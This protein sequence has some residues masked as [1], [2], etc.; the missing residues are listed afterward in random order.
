MKIE[1]RLLFEIQLYNCEIQ[2]KIFGIQIDGF[3][4][5]F[6]KTYLFEIFNF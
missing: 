2:S 3:H 5:H 1:I 4:M 6:L